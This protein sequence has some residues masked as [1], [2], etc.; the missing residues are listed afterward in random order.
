MSWDAVQRRLL[1]AL[2]H[3]VPVLR[4]ADWPGDAGHAPRVQRALPAE[5]MAQAAGSSDARAGRQASGGTAAVMREA[6]LWA[7]LARASGC[8]P[9]QVRTLLAD[10]DVRGLRDAAAKRALWPRLRA[11]RRERARG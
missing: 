9:A 10:V 11:L 8:D 1:G 4:S 2:G 5:A 6:R 7:A 3:A